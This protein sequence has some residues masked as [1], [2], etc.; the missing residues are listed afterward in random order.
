M[1][2][3]ISKFGRAILGRLHPALSGAKEPRRNDRRHRGESDQRTAFQRDRDRLLYTDAFN[4]LSGVTQVARTGESYIYHDR[5]SH[6][7][8]VGQVGR[9]LTEHLREVT[10]D[11]VF[12]NHTG[13]IP[14][15]VEAAA[16]A[17]D[18]GHPPFGHT[19]EQQLDDCVTSEGVPEGFEAN[20]QSFRIVTK[21]ATHRSGYDGLDLTRATLN[22]ILKY[23]WARDD[24]GKKSGKWGYYRTEQTDFDFARELAQGQQQSIEA[25]IMDWAD[26][27]AYAVHDLDDFYRAGLLPFDQ[28]LEDSEQRS[29]FLDHLETNTDI[30]TDSWDPEEFIESMS[31]FAVDVL[32]KPYTGDPTQGGEMNTFTSHLIR[33]YLGY[34]SRDITPIEL[35]KSNHGLDIHVNSVLRCEVDTLIELTRYYIINNSALM[36][37]QHGQRKVIRKLFQILMKEAVPEAKNRG[38][39]PSPYRDRISELDKTGTKNERTRIV[40][41]LL[42]SM[43]EQQT[44]ELYE[45]LEGT[46][47]GSLQ[48]RIIR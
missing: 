14:S 24:N 41:D 12:E 19:A 11:E 48:D 39:I 47:P 6:S 20:A 33:R 4:R 10:P 46:S 42:T 7:L 8:K 13:P 2:R 25:Q 22:G 29:D 36:A 34:P 18:L 32:K 45:R 26:D 1:D 40:V 31:N 28:I 5:L 9:R 37:Q 43:T 3:N 15:V 21:L 27:V 17:H 23:P 30:G 16:L 44:I 38:I 35:R